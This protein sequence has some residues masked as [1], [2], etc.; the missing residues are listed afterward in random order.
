[1]PINHRD[2]DG[3]IVAKFLLLELNK[4]ISQLG[5]NVNSVCKPFLIVILIGLISQCGARRSTP[6]ITERESDSSS[7]QP[8]GAQTF[9]PITTV[10]ENTTTQASPESA[11]EQADGEESAQSQQA[12]DSAEAEVLKQQLED[13]Q[14]GREVVESILPSLT[15]VSGLL[16]LDVAGQSVV[17]GGNIIG[18]ECNGQL[19]QRYKLNLHSD[20]YFQ[21]VAQNSLKCLSKNSDSD[22]IEQTTCLAE[23][24]KMESQLFTAFESLN[25][26]FKIKNKLSGLCFSADVNN[27]NN[28][29]L[30]QCNETTTLFKTL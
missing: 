4:G 8:Q 20:G 12:T 18:F 5:G 6:A 30:V 16:C 29:H 10:P 14:R 19:N 9:P 13:E 1:M 27:G 28:I 22:N 17:D 3:A 11:K 7:A 21:V 24:T 25:G 15:I 26:E 23:D 2:T